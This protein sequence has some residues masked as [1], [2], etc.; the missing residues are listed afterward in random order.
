MYRILLLNAALAW[1]CAASAQQATQPT[2]PLR[3]ALQQLLAQTAVQCPAQAA[4]LAAEKGKTDAKNF[5]FKQEFHLSLC[6]CQPAKVKALL[7]QRPAAELAATVTET[8]AMEYLTN[9]ALQPCVGAVFRDMFAG[10]LC[11][12]L[13]PAAT[14]GCMAPEVN[15]ISDAE[16][17]R[18]GIAYHQYGQALAKAREEGKAAPG[19]GAAEKLVQ[20]V[21]KCSSTASRRD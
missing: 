13:M 11:R 18:G 7:E 6:Q 4:A 1:A 17:L 14:C 20:M 2:L 12:D 9:H 15:R 10:N 5:R 16:L 8:Q 19:A 21:E 3:S